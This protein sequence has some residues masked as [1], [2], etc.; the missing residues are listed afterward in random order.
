[1]ASAVEN[2]L[3]VLF[4]VTKKYKESNFCRLEAEYALQQKKPFIPLIM[5][6]GYKADGWLGILIG[7]RYCWFD[8]YLKKIN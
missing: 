5:E 3:C 1:M 8:N 2:S 7:T 6:R 4:C